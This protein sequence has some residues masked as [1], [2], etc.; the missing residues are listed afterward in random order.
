MK[1]QVLITALLIPFILM[2]CKTAT[3]TEDPILISTFA[4]IE[5]LGKTSQL[6]PTAYLEQTL[7]S[8]KCENPCWLGIEPGTASNLENIEEILIRFYGNENVY[9]S[10]KAHQIVYWRIINSDFSQHGAVVLDED[11]QITYIQVFF[12]EGR[13]TVDNLISVI[14]EPEY[15]LLVGDNRPHGFRCDGVW[16]ML[17][18]QSGIEVLTESTPESIKQSQ[19]I[20]YIGIEKPSTLTDKH[21]PDGYKAVQWEG[22][23][24]YCEN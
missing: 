3:K 23:R 24:H 19:F 9:R 12:N 22:Y 21:Y 2:S 6:N 11:N 4:P 17:Y 16:G 8:D 20:Y 15:V 5:N 18:L 14:G 7:I 1:T 13:I 10:P